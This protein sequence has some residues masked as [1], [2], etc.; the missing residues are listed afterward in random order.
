MKEIYDKI[1]ERT[2][3]IKYKPV[4]NSNFVEELRLLANTMMNNLIEAGFL[5]IRSK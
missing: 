5:K 2:F 3:L 1:G 4:L